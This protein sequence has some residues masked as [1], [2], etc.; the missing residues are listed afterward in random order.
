MIRDTLGPTLRAMRERAGLTATG[1]ARAMAMDQS[2][3]SKTERGLSRPPLDTIE[4]WA[5]ACNMRAD[6]VFTP[7][8]V[9]VKRWGHEAHEA[10]DLIDGADPEDRAYLLDTLRRLVRGR[11]P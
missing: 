7:A 8:H 5:T 4:A 1:L 6:L 10:A 2:T 11:T 9:K 3:V